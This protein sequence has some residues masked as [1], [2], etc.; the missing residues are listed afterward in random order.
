MIKTV[1][2]EHVE[3][4]SHL[5]DDHVLPPGSHIYLLLLKAIEDQG[6]VFTGTLKQSKTKRHMV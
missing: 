5:H 2:W 4:Y 1:T 6:S 3:T